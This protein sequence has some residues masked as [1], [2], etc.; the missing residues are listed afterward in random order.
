MG[1]ELE[2]INEVSFRVIGAC[3]EVHKS[4][5]CGLLESAYRK[6]LESEFRSSGLEFKSEL[7]VPVVYKGVR[8]DKAYRL[9]FLIEDLVIL[10]I[11]SVHELCTKH[12][13]QLLTYLRLANKK[14]GLLVNFGKP[15]LKQGIVRV[16][17]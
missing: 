4:L 8:V 1:K 10:E 5:G 11:K 14:L 6:C 13:M 7:E 12:K 17:N 15:M 3:V 9:D 16:I 2:K